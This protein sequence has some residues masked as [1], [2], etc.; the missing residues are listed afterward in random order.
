MGTIKASLGLS[1]IGRLNFEKG[2]HNPYIVICA[3]H[4]APDSPAARSLEKS[5][6]GLQA[7]LPLV[8]C[9]ECRNSKEQRGLRAKNVGM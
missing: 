7:D 4:D 3:D 8:F 6:H 5:V 1:N 2:E 9:K